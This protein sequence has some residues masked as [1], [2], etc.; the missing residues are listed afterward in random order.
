MTV[1]DTVKTV[2][3]PSQITLREIGEVPKST[4]SSSTGYGQR[5]SIKPGENI[6]SDHAIFLEGGDIFAV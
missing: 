5:F 6:R 3:Q 1:D 2:P 4:S